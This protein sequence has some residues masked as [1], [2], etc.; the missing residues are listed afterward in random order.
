MYPGGLLL[1]GW[2]GSPDPIGTVAELSLQLGFMRWKYRNL[3]FL[4][5]VLTAQRKL[6]T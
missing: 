5:K 3:S 4:S 6:E 2:S 1:L